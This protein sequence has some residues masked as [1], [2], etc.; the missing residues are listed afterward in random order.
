MKLSETKIT[1]VG[2]YRCCMDLFNKDNV[3]SDVEIA[4]KRI[5][6]HCKEEFQLQENNIWIPTWQLENKK[7]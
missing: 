4:E 5:C 3:N 1:M 2:V 7:E 6:P